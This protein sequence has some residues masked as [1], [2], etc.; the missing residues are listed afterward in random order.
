MKLID[1][2]LAQEKAIGKTYMLH[3][4]TIA[5]G[6]HF[7]RALGLAQDPQVRAHLHSLAAASLVTTGDQRG[8]DHLREAL[9][10]LDPKVNPLGTANAIAIEGRFHHLAGRQQKSIDLLERA[11]GLI[12]PIAGQ[13]SVTPFAASIIPPIYGFLAGAYHGY[14]RFLDADRWAQRDV[15]FGIAHDILLAQALGL[16]YLGEDAIHSGNF[17]AAIEYAERQREIAAKLQSRERRGWTHFIAA[18]GAFYSGDPE[19]AEREFVEGIALAESIGE[20]RLA[21]LLKGGFAVF[22]ADQASNYRPG[23]IGDR[24]GAPERTGGGIDRVAGQRQLDE[25]LQTALDNFRAGETLGLLYS[26]FECHRCLAEVRFRRGEFDEAQR[27]CAAAS[28]LVSGT[29][30]RVSRLWLGPLY[31]EV[32]LAAGLRAEAEGKP[33]EAAAN[34]GLAAE[35][36]GRYQELV[37]DCQSPRFSREAARLAESIASAK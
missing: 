37:A 15:A 31:I 9:S 21:S 8:L 23:S 10:V 25:A 36:L 11:A 20:L 22:Q 28:E 33:D 24:N 18:Q 34:R 16:E 14:G 3:G 27:V 4:E 26:R 30:S 2:Q 29:E 12:A 6:E 35:H 5:A 7:E 32:L 17:V 13:D 19:R 1:E